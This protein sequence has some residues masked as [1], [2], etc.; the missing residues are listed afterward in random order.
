MYGGIMR[1]EVASFRLDSRCLSELKSEVKTKAVSLNSYVNQIFTDH[2]DW[3]AN[4][5]KAGMVCFPK[6]LLVKIMDKL[7]EEEIILIAEN[8]AH[9]EMK[10]IILMMRKRPD[11]SAFLDLI[12]SWMKA[13]DFH[14]R[15]SVD[16]STHE[17]II[18]H[19]MSKNWSLFM[20]W[21]FRFVFDMLGAKESKFDKTEKTLVFQ[22]DVESR[23]D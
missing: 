6:T 9:N 19:E 8:M 11:P 18:Q 16:D 1:S 23:F 5:S 4:A 22:V 7:P 3:H 2:V 21:L 12:E 13:S 17:F 14:F 20:G 15:H 10:E